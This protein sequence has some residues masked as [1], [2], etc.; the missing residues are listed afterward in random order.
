MDMYTL[1]YLKWISNK[2]LLYSTWNSVQCYVA[3]WMGGELGRECICM[4]E[5]LRCSAETITALLISY[6]PIQ[7][8]TLKKRKE[9]ILIAGHSGKALVV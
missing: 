7:N 8:E 5:S 3:A 6:T 9:K 4:A 2:D 1:L